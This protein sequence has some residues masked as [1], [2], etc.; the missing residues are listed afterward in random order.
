M[1][2]ILYIVVAFSLL[3]TSA[4]MAAD[5]AKTILARHV[6]AIKKGDV[7]ALTADYADDALVIAPQGIVHTPT[8]KGDGPDVFV[9]KAN[10]RKLFVAITGKENLPALRSMTAHSENLPGGV[11]LMHWEQFPGTAKEADGV[12]VFRIRNGKIV[13]QAVTIDQR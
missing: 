5:S 4:A 10:A 3:G 7:N 6:A 13:Y 2:K 1:K 11:T 12:D 8:H 9:G